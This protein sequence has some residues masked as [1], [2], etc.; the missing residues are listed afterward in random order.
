[1]RSF[2]FMIA[3][4]FA[5]LATATVVATTSMNCAADNC[6]RGTYLKWDDETEINRLIYSSYPSIRFPNPFGNC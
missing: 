5:A 4:G 1:M 3:G 6:L 2:T